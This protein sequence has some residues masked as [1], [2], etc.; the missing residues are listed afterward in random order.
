MIVARICS[1]YSQPSA[2]PIYFGYAPTLTPPTANPFAPPYFVLYSLFFSPSSAHRPTT[3]PPDSL[4]SAVPVTAISRDVLNRRPLLDGGNITDDLPTPHSSL[5]SEPPPLSFSPPRVPLPDRISSNGAGDRIS[6]VEV[7]AFFL[8]KDLEVAAALEAMRW[9]SQEIEAAAA[10]VNVDGGDVG[11]VIANDI[12]IVA[13]LEEMRR[14][15]EQRAV[16]AAAATAVGVAD[17][18]VW[19]VLTIHV[20][21]AAVLEAERHG[22]EGRAVAADE[23][24]MVVAREEVEIAL[25]TDI[26]IAAVLEAERRDDDERVAAAAQAD[27]VVA[28]GDVESEMGKRSEVDGGGVVEDGQGTDADVVS[29]FI[30]LLTFCCGGV[31]SHVSYARFRSCLQHVLEG[32][33]IYFP[34]MSEEHSTRMGLHVPT[35]SIAYRGGPNRINNERPAAA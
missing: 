18:D 31:I 16:A 22:D 23:V 27:V 24:G 4:P 17:G 34:S 29:A 14:E 35:F 28:G 3:A 6:K 12:D 15:D 25:T 11:S 13:V 20:D 32:V 2:S 1:L 26:D 9:E 21:V 5:H 7:P 8:T 30:F 10:G 33:H 19:G